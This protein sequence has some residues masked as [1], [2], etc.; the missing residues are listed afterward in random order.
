[1]A[2]NLSGEYFETC[3]C[4]VLCPCILSQATAPPTEGYC[5]AVLAFRVDA[6]AADGL[7]LAGTHAVIALRT[8]G[9]MVEGRGKR[10]IYVDSAAS[11]PQRQA[12]AAI[13]SGERGGPPEGVGGLAP[14]LLGVQTARISFQME[15]ASRSL[16]VEGIGEQSITGLPGMSGETLVLTNTG[17]PANTNLAVARAGATARFKDAAFDIDNAGKNGH[18][19]PFTWQG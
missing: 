15:G 18:F 2:W 7:N 3:S 8:D 11:E 13:F 9:P 10:E 16:T 17:H 4:A 14:E 1:M 5:E 12:L 6:G 19:A